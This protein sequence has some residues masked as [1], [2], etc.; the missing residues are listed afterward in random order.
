MRGKK[1]KIVTSP[2]FQGIELPEIDLHIYVVLC[3]FVVEPCCGVF[4]IVII[5]SVSKQLVWCESVGVR[6]GF[7]GGG[8]NVRAASGSTVMTSGAPTIFRHMAFLLASIARRSLA[9]RFVVSGLFTAEAAS[10]A[11]SF[12]GF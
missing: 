8:V 2:P 6:W 4:I 7:K 10:D 9:S 5:V 3:F 1:I 11:I 12:S